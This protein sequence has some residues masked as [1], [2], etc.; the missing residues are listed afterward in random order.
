M[1]ILND[2]WI[3]IRQKN[4]VQELTLQ[5]GDMVECRRPNTTS[6]VHQPSVHAF[7]DA[8]S[9]SVLG[10]DKVWRNGWRE[11]ECLK[12]PAKSKEH[13][14]KGHVCSFL[15]KLV[16]PCVKNLRPCDKARF[17]KVSKRDGAQSLRLPTIL[18][19][20][21]LYEFPVSIITVPMRTLNPSCP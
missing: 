2:K 17:R 10:P 19:W 7:A 13:E 5:A 21:L 15:E 3:R 9:L 8:Q 6:A 16:K 11:S 14:A 1:T 4:S 12:K 18:W 20:A